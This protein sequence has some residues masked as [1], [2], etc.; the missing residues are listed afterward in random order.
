MANLILIEVEVAGRTCIIGGFTTNGWV[1]S[2]SEDD[3]N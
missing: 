1:T 2:L 3:N